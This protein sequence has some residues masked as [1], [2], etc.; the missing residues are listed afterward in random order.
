MQPDILESGFDIIKG[1]VPVTALYYAAIRPRIKEAIRD[2][3]DRELWRQ[4]V[5]L[6]LDNYDKVEVKLDGIDMLLRE[7]ISR[8]VALET[9]QKLNP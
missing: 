7:V 5:E 1:V 4:K 2:G 6:R 3:N 8:L 9:T